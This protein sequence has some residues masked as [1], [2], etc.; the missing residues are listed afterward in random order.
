V[1]LDHVSLS[2]PAMIGS[3][4]GSDVIYELYAVAQR[5]RGHSAGI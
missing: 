4:D 1:Q 5:K 3:D 2:A